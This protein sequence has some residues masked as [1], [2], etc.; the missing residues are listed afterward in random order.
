MGIWGSPFGQGSL[1][2]NPCASGPLT[3]SRV[4]RWLIDARVA[5]G[6]SYAEELDAGALVALSV[7]RALS[8]FQRLSL[9]ARTKWGKAM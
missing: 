6:F 2:R 7:A 3:S 4:P 8:I 1:S 5:R 9:S